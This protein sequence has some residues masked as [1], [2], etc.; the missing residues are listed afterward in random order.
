MLVNSTLWP[1]KTSNRKRMWPIYVLLLIVP[2]LSNCSAALSTG[3]LINRGES[4]PRMPN[5]DIWGSPHSAK[6]WD[7]RL[8]EPHPNYQNLS[9]ASL[10]TA[11]SSSAGTAR[12]NGKGKTVQ[13]AVVWKWR[14][15][16]NGWS[17]SR[18]D[19]FTSFIWQNQRFICNELCKRKFC[20]IS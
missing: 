18:S 6:K 14:C 7:S 8:G 19:W 13:Q 1:K 5:Y 12:R 20:C 2:L 11:R 3:S 17:R 4:W 15:P 9:S 10:L 16:W